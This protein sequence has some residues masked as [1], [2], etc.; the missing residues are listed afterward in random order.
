MLL[1][2]GQMPRRQHLRKLLAGWLSDLWAIAVVHLSAHQ[3]QIDR[4]NDSFLKSRCPSPTQIDTGRRAVH[5]DTRT[6]QQVPAQIAMSKNLKS[7]GNS[8]V[9]ED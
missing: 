4:S 7:C 6:A 8:V 5:A 3:G 1:A 2:Y 9:D